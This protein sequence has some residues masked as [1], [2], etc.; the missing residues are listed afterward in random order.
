MVLTAHME[1]LPASSRRSRDP[2]RK[3][4]LETAGTLP[5][6]A[7]T[8]V[9]VHNI[10]ATGMLIECRHALAISEILEID[11]PG[12]ESASAKIV[13]MSGLLHGCQFLKPV[14]K[15]VLSAV[16]LRSVAGQEMDTSA[17]SVNMDTGEPFGVRLQRLRKERGLTLAEVASELAVSK[18]TVWAWEQGRARPIQERI[19]LLAQV[20]G[21]SSHALHTGRAADG[22][23]ELLDRSKRHIADAYGT[24][25]ENVRIMIEL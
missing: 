23:G 12:A 4:T 25:P 11:L 19:D 10:S 24:K 1:E 15:A 18:P 17:T 8:D 7:P 2:R 6:G 20:L 21:T 22:L 13:W 9:A 3:L 14:S 16:Q 5:S